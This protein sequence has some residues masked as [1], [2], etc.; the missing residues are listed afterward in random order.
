MSWRIAGWCAVLLCGAVVVARLLQGADEGT[1]SWDFSR[2]AGFTSYLML[3]AAVTSGI[4]VQRRIVATR[5]QR[6]LLEGHR[7]LGALALAFAAAHAFALLLDPVVRFSL[8]NVFVPFTSG[9]RPIAVGLGSLALWTATT[10]LGTTALAHLFGRRT[11][12]RIHLLSYPAFALALTH[13]LLAG[14]DSGATAAVLLYGATAASV[15]GALALRVGS[16]SWTA[17]PGPVAAN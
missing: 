16:R 15:A 10:V 12:W 9:Y 6:S 4:L 11:W 1:A 5:L 3:W 8:T 2:A 7:M 14:T 17:S 13:G